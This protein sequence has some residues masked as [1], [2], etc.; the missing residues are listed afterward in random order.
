MIKYL[1]LLGFIGFLVFTLG[2]CSGSGSAEDSDASQEINEAFASL[3]GG[4]FFPTDSPGLDPFPGDDSIGNPIDGGNG[5]DFFPHIPDV[6]SG[7]RGDDNNCNLNP[8]IN[9]APNFSFHFQCSQKIEICAYDPNTPRDFEDFV[10]KLLNLEDLSITAY[11]FCGSTLDP[12]HYLHYEEAWI[13]VILQYYN[14]QTTCEPNPVTGRTECSL[15]VSNPLFCS[16][17]EHLLKIE[18]P[19]LPVPDLAPVHICQIEILGVCI[20][21]IEP[22]PEDEPIEG[23]EVQIGDV[24]LAY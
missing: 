17:V 9:C 12:D 16:D 18:T 5:A 14:G 7:P 21:D 15:E 2:A 24:C 4:S 6:P 22:N 8:D 23:C 19:G 13:L 20:D 1:K 10:A 11:R 3:G